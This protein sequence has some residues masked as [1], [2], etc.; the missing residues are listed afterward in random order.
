MTK[1]ALIGAGGRMG[2]RLLACIHEDVACT[3]AGAGESAGSAVL[4][5]DAGR[6]AGLDEL[7]ISITDQLDEVLA[8]ADVIS[9]K[10]QKHNIGPGACSP[11]IDFG[12]HF[13]GE[14]TPMA[15]VVG[16]KVGRLCSIA[17]SPIH[18]ANK[19]DVQ[20]LFLQS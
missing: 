3:L 7:G 15:F 12:K 14:P 17:I 1:I 11:P 18:A 9:A 5:Q 20:A 13:I 2:R 8:T 10:M 16:I 6:V 19:I 4:G